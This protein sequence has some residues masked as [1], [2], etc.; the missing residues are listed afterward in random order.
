MGTGFK[1]KQVKSKQEE[2]ETRKNAVLHLT[3]RATI[4]GLG[5]PNHATMLYRL[6][7]LNPDL[8]YFCFSTVGVTF[9]NRRE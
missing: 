8:T 1:N 6:N 9:D 7:N 3:I 2:E 4:S 5:T